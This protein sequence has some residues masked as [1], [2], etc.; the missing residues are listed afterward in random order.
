MPID[1]ENKY[2]DLKR[3]IIDK[4]PWLHCDVPR[5]HKNAGSYIFLACHATDIITGV[6][7]VINLVT[8]STTP[9]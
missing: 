9:A 7:D 4:P 8:S 6:N 3:C 1:L 5:T 2:R